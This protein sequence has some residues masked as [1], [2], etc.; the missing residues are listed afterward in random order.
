M[1]MGLF[2]LLAAT[3]E[4]DIITMLNTQFDANH[5]KNPSDAH[6]ALDAFALGTDLKISYA[7]LG[8]YPIDN[9]ERKAWF[10]YLDTLKLCSSDTP[11]VTGH[12]RIVLA[13][14][15]ALEANPPTPIVTKHHDGTGQPTDQVMV[16]MGNPVI[17]DSPVV[18]YGLRRAAR[19]TGRV[20][21]KK[22]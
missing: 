3:A 8:I 2:G 6:K 20:A 13:R 10:K 17:I 1:G 7:L 16:T 9:K 19:K 11:N 21:R 15:A 4:D 14:K 18:L 5:I 12:D 22:A